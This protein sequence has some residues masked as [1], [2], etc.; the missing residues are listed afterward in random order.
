MAAGVPLTG[1]AITT[2][3]PRFL[4][5]FALGIALVIAGSALAPSP[6]PP[7]WEHEPSEIGDLSEEEFTRLEDEVERGARSAVVAVA[8]PED[9]FAELVRDALDELPEFVQEDLRNGNL[10]VLASDGGDEWHALGLYMGGHVA[11]PRWQRRILIFRDTLTRAYGH[12]P[13][14]LRRQVAITV[15]HEVA[16][17]YGADE[18]RVRAL[19][20]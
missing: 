9:A 15:R 4:L 5:V 17:F 3:D 12:D 8:E 7:S 18:D 14:E 1:V 11:D 20:L 2:S 16:H 10:A 13:D 6:Q 19:G